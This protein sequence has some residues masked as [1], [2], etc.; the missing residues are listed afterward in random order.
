MKFY[1]ID[2]PVPGRTEPCTDWSTSW[3]EAHRIGRAHSDYY[4]VSLVELPERKGEMLAFLRQNIGR[5]S[6]D[7][8]NAPQAAVR[9]AGDSASPLL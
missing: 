8:A 1:R 5:R 2:W 6:I 7:P 9:G 3:D 4:K